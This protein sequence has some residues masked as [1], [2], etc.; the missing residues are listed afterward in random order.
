LPPPPMHAQLLGVLMERQ[1]LL[2]A[3]ARGALS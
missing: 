2:Y 1:K 3:G